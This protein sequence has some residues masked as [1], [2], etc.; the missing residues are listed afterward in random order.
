MIKVK[1]L[2]I[3]ATVPTRN[4]PSDAGLDLYSDA[5]V[6]IPTGG[7]AIINT[8]IAIAIPEGFVARIAPRSGL[9]VNHGIDTLAGV[10]DSSY[11]GE[12]LVV[13]INHGT[14]TCQVNRGDKI[15]QLLI[16]P[17]E[18]WIPEVVDSLADTTRGTNGFG[19]SGK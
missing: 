14:E 2:T 9:A 5:W 10:V 12:I 6:S 13:L 19:S 15:A 7:R 11:R 17:V 8:S 4:N 1:P 18:L 16:Q 3:T